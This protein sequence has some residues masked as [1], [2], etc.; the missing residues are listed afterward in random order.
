MLRATRK[1]IRVSLAVSIRREI[2]RCW[3][4]VDGGA[5]TLGALI[6]LLSETFNGS[7]GEEEARSGLGTF[8]RT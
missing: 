7:R 1:M 2:R 4:G 8:C 3:G 6:L 5:A